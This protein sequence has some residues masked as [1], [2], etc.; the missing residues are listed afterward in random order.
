L[1]N[2]TTI[3]CNQGPILL[4]LNP[5]IVPVGSDF[6]EWNLVGNISPDP[7]SPNSDASINTNI[8]PA[9][10]HFVLS[11]TNSFGCVTKDSVDVIVDCIVFPGQMISLSGQNSGSTNLIAWA[12]DENANFIKMSLHYSLDGLHFEQI[13]NAALSGGQFAHANLPP[14]RHYYR[15]LAEDADGAQTLSNVI[16]LEVQMALNWTLQ[17]NPAHNQVSIQASKEIN[18]GELSLY[19][20]KGRLLLNKDLPTGQTFQLELG[21][22]AKGAYIL[23]LKANGET[24]R[25]RLMIQ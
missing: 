15:L 11:V 20:L 14:G 10:Y 17:P 13:A 2:D 22:L 9:T 8:Y 19:D 1:I 7:N 4:P 6:Y 5:D 23:E 16:N 3:D 25:Q 12:L 21:A 24:S 18:Q